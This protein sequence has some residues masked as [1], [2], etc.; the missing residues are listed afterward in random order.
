MSPTKVELKAE[1]DKIVKLQSYF[2]IGEAQLHL[3]LQLLYY[4]LKTLG[5]IEK[6]VPWKSKAP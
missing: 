1:Q 5:N 6:A 4:T 2:V 3:I